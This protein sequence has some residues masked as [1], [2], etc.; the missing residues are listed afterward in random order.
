MENQKNHWK[1]RAGSIKVHNLENNSQFSEFKPYT[2][3]EEQK[4]IAETEAWKKENA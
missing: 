1:L 2:K 3:E 4:A